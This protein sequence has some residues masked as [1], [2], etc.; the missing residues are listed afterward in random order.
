MVNNH[1]FTELWFT[2]ENDQKNTC[3]ISTNNYF[4]Q[5][6][7]KK[8]A[9]EREI[10]TML[11]YWWTGLYGTPNRKKNCLVYMLCRWSTS[12]LQSG[13]HVGALAP[14]WAWAAN[15]K[16]S[17]RLSCYDCTRTTWLRG[18][19]VRS[20]LYWAIPGNLRSQKFYHHLHLPFCSRWAVTPIT[21]THIYRAGCQLSCRQQWWLDGASALETSAFFTGA[22][23]LAPHLLHRLGT[24][25]SNVF[26]QQE[27]L[28]KSAWQGTHSS[29]CH[30]CSWSSDTQCAGIKR[31]RGHE[32]DT[33]VFSLYP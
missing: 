13:F 33:S 26:I 17:A 16:L 9:K 4:L 5:W 11:R 32:S 27:G 24:E 31:K 2:Q 28:G 3:K 30:L 22:G 15:L 7:F 14:C 1:D 6:G 20:A 19:W 29:L 12:Q 23:K 25:N 8:D 10:G 21:N 18:S